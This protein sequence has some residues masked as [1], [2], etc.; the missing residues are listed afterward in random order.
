VTLDEFM[1]AFEGDDNTQ[2]EVQVLEAFQE[3][4]EEDRDPVRRRIR[5]LFNQIDRD[6]SGWLAR[7]ELID[8]LE[9]LGLENSAD[10]TEELLEEVDDGDGRVTVDEFILAFRQVEKQERKAARHQARIWRQEQREAGS[11]RGRARDLFRK[12]ERESTV[13]YGA[14]QVGAKQLYDGLWHAGYKNVDA[15]HIKKMMQIGDRN[16]DGVLEFEEF[17][18]CFNDVE[19]EEELSESEDDSDT[20]VFD[21]DEE[22]AAEKARLKEEGEAETVRRKA[23]E[24]ERAR[25]QKLFDDVDDDRNGSLNRDEVYLLVRT[26]GLDP[27]AKELNEAMGEM[28]ADGS[29]VVMPDEFQD[30]WIAQ[31]SGDAGAGAGAAIF[32]RLGKGLLNIAGARS[33]GN[34]LGAKER[35]GVLHVTVVGARELPY[36]E[37]GGADPFCTLSFEGAGYKTKP[38][39]NTLQP[40][41]EE[42]FTFNVRDRHSALELQV[43][44]YDAGDDDLIGHVKITPEE[45][46]GEVGKQAEEREWPIKFAR[47]GLVQSAMADGWQAKKKDALMQE[48]VARGVENLPKEMTKKKIVSVLTEL[49]LGQLRLRVV[50]R[51]EGQF[52]WEDD[53]GDDTDSDDDDEMWRNIADSIG[54]KRRPKDCLVKWIYKDTRGAELPEDAWDEEELEKLEAGVKRFAEAVSPDQTLIPVGGLTRVVTAVAALQ[55]VEQGTLQ[56]DADISDISD[57]DI[58]RNLKSTVSGRSVEDHPTITPEYALTN[59]TG[60]DSKWT[61]TAGHGQQ[62]KRRKISSLE[63][64]CKTCCQSV[65]VL[66]LIGLALLNLMS[67]VG[68]VSMDLDVPEIVLDS[69]SS[70]AGLTDVNIAP[71]AN[72]VCGKLAQIVGQVHLFIPPF[73]SLCRCYVQMEIQMIDVMIGPQVEN[74]IQIQDSW[75]KIVVPRVQVCHIS[76][77]QVF[78]RSANFHNLS[79]LAQICLPI[80]FLRRRILG[81]TTVG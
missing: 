44:D 60:L 58:I 71:V 18:L 75:V 49:M 73:M 17:L 16:G 32:G 78:S 47:G 23:E 21:E 31:Q 12:I 46:T 27:T 24:A 30:W 25:V 62:D 28:D 6:G 11:N 38:R 39:K 37:S 64:C 81:A 56:L 41:W 20:D 63:R 2:E 76:P 15:A 54:T 48:L 36:M 77:N 35:V 65:T 45:V 72:G 55:L 5:A 26:L 22:S 59:R 1:A 52:G 57:L 67:S 7:D 10:A 43:L 40:T 80:P 42:A 66:G 70:W 4:E 3:A 34:T 29:G 33:A 69:D 68:V 9:E 50:F 8:G 74:V 61:G 13:K 14:G 51:P 79:N 19:S 53:G